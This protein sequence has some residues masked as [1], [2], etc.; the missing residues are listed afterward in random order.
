MTSLR[1]TAGLISN[2]TLYINRTDQFLK[3]RSLKETDFLLLIPKVLQYLTLSK[4]T[5]VV[6]IFAPLI[7]LLHLRIRNLTKYPQRSANINFCVLGD[8]VGF[9]GSLQC[10][11]VISFFVL[12]FFVR[13]KFVLLW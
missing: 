2:V 6:H 7:F 9:S 8:F 4:N 12:V 11:N 3:F 5:V 10:G 13:N 1:P